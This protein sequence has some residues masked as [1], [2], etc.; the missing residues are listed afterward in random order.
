MYTDQHIHSSW[1]GDSET[2]ASDQADR[3]I[4]LGMERIC[5]T[6]HHDPFVVSDVDFELDF[7][8]Y[9]EDMPKL[10]EAYSGRL[11]I[12]IGV[13]LG[14]QTHIADHLE[15]LAKAY[16]FDL[17]IGSVHFVEGLDPYY[18]E[19]FKKYGDRAYA[20]YFETVLEN[21]RLMSCYDI[22]GHL[23]YIVRYGKG[24]GL[25]YSYDEYSDLIDPILRI[26]I[27][28]GKALECNTGGMSRGLSEPDPCYDVFRRYREM[29][30]EL[31]TFGSDAHDPSTLGCYFDEAG[32]MLRDIGF[33]YY[34]VYRGRTPEMHKL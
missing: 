32:A 3:A 7:K 2:P 19:Y 13:E 31:I 14:L 29:G 9:F 16:P 18:P 22:L 8:G 5:F 4:A 23:D 17:I 6:D 15:T 25:T 28:G 11:D 10:R 1:S 26:V 20:L 34:T 27:D 24:F 12:G 21:I 30:G 33:R